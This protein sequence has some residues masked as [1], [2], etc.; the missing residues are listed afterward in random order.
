MISHMPRAGT[1]DHAAER[2]IRALAPCA[3]AATM[4]PCALACDDAAPRAARATMRQVVQTG[5]AG[6]SRRG[7]RRHQLAGALIPAAVGGNRRRSGHV[8]AP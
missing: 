2:L 7:R 3:L 8:S 4:P 6:R 5:S 1:R